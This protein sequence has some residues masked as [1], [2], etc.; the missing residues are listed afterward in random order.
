MSKLIIDVSYHNGVINWERVKASGCAGAILRC[1]YGD[2]IAS[3]DDKQWIR[4]LSECE[5]LGI[6]VGAYLYSYATSDRQAQSELD[7][8]LR[9]IKG[10]T[11]QLPIFLDVEEPGT[12]HYAP[13]C[14]EIVCEGL[15]ANGYVPGIYASLSWF[16]GYLGTVRGKYIEW[17]A[18]YKN[19]PEDSYKG[20]YA[21][22]QYASD[23]QVDG[24]SGRVDV[25]HCYMEF[26]GS[27]TPV[28]PSA[29]SKPVEKKD[30]GQVDITYQAYTTKW[31]PA[32]TN[33]ADWA[34]KGDDV[35]IKWLAI[36]VSKG[37]IRAR[38]Y[39]QANGWL[40]YLT[41]GNS[42]D[43]NDKVNGIL[44]DGSEILAVELYY[45]TPDGY[46]YKMVHYRVSVQNNKNFY[47]DQVDT[48]KASGMD[49]FAGD[50]YRFIDKFQAWIE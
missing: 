28:T 40:P 39:T 41:F 45:I 47:A 1:G 13:R 25:N 19:L 6:P 27:A 8:I 43:L 17:M 5:R 37:S 44:G 15:K 20:Q 38:V 49:G 22:W 32:V 35:P 31:W 7:H 18:R 9:L 4:N 21:I 34:G 48:L 12:Q 2:D 33:K 14:C 42:Y 3:Q 24:V 50:K 11:F 29:P 10:H 23:G 16:N 26:G 46:K 36:K 30:L